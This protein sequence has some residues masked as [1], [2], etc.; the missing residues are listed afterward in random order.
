MCGIGRCSS[1]EEAPWS[2]RGGALLPMPRSLPTPRQLFRQLDHGEITR[3]QFRELMGEHAQL[4]IGEMEEAHANPIAAW[5]ESIRNR[6][7]AARLAHQHGEALVRDIF[8]ALSDLPEFPLANWLWNADQYHVPLHCFLRSRLEP[9][10]RVLKISSAA[11]L[12]TITVEYS[13]DRGTVE[14]TRFIFTRDRFGRL[15]VKSRENV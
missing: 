4:I 1:A 7:A 14:R 5:I 15:H 11:F 10:F 9:V 2:I 13:V 12:L 8:T 3:E 6:R